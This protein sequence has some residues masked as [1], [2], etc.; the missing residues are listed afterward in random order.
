MICAVFR[1]TNKTHILDRK[2]FGGSL[3][4]IFEDVMGYLQA[5]LKF[6]L[7]SSRAGTG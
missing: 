2:D 6:G 5:K 3:Y 7:D 4:D 1:G